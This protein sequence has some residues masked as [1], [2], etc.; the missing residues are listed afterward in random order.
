[1]AGT[2]VQPW[3]DRAIRH[4]LA[5]VRRGAAGDAGGDA[6]RDPLANPAL[7]SGHDGHG[8]TDQ[9]AGAFLDCRPG[10]G[11]EGTDVSLHERACVLPE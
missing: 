6:R 4:G 7:L 1:M 8:A 10:N 11:D 9:D 3:F 2:I 5:N